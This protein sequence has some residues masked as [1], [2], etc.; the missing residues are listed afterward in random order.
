MCII[1]Y[2][3]IR[4]GDFAKKET[5]YIPLYIESRITS[6][7]YAYNHFDLAEKDECNQ[8]FSVCKAL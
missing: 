4:I 1:P 6:Y 5:T 3:H 8:D 7:H 2:A